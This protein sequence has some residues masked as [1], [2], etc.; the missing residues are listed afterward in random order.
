MSD[1]PEYPARGEIENV[2]D[3]SVCECWSWANAGGDDAAQQLLT[4]HHP[5][6]KQG[7]L[8]KSAFKLIADLAH[9][10]AVWGSEEDGI[11]DFAW[12]P[13]RRAKA[14]Q[15]VFLEKGGGE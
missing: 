2:V 3:T 11:P 6:C 1:K 14:L 7:D 10:L 9:A 8:R 4:G 13:Y 5:Q 15:G 12:E